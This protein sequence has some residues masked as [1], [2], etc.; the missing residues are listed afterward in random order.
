[1]ANDYIQQPEAGRTALKYAQDVLSGTIIACR[2][3]K[4]ACQRFLDDLQ[5][6]EKRGLYFDGDAA[7]H[8]VD[9]FGF[10]RHIKGDLAKTQETAGFL[11]APWQIFIMAN[12]FGWKK[13]ETGFR[14][15]NETHIEIAKKN[16]KST[17]MAGIG[18]Y[19][20]FADGEPGAEVYSG[21]TTKEQASIIFDVASKMVERSPHLKKHIEVW[22]NNLHTKE[23][24]KFEPLAAEK[25][26]L[27]GKHI[28]CVL[29]D[30]LHEHPN[31]DVYDVLSRGTIQ[32]SQPLIL[33]ITTAGTDRE[34]ICYVQREYATKVLQGTLIADEF[35]GFICCADDGDDPQDDNALLKANP[36]IGFP[37][38]LNLNV[39]KLARGKAVSI[40]SELNEF[41]RKHLNIWTSAETAW[42]AA[43][44]WERCTAYDP[45]ATNAQELRAQALEKMRGIK[46]V[47][48]DPKT[49]IETV[50][51]PMP[52]RCNAGLD[53]AE[54]EDFSALVLTFPPCERVVRME[55]DPTTKKPFEKVLQ[56]ADSKWHILPWFWIPEAFVEEQQKKCR[57][58]YD[59]WIRAK[60]IT[61]TPG[62]TVAQEEIRKTIIELHSTYR[63][64]ELGFD[65]WGMEWLGP[66]LVKYGVKAIKIPQ[67][68]ELLNSPTKN[69]TAFIHNQPDVILEHYNNPVIRWM[70]SNV[71]LLTDTNGNQRPDKG[72]S[73]NKID[74]I[75]AAVMAVGRA[76]ATPTG[77]ADNPDRFRVR[78]L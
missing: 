18:L 33:S 22:R 52:R 53:I 72:K 62:N 47:F 50:S 76:L 2:W 21:A 15:F 64:G 38:G 68:F 3:T 49:G 31:R 57:A 65:G 7:Q 28:H 37:G 27:D 46:V 41:L 25:G 59:V 34:G 73:R 11:L 16:G 39:L 51:Y 74:G 44:A 6:G 36:N 1:M 20:L 17:M 48:K 5:F 32:R 10:L 43:G 12:L 40:P 69:L 54:C 60:F 8:A 4:L 56:E 70:A 13:T 24:S 42:L 75:V 9:F 78:M 29:I 30:E 71:Q 23:G 19:M 55:I 26:P 77:G 45:N 35:F 63:M 14:R 58:P 61:A 66:E 67:R